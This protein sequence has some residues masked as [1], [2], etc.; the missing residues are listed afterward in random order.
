MA[1]AK[2]S[3]M[4]SIPS[5]TSF[6][7]LVREVTKKMAESAGFSDGTADRLALAV[8][9]ATTNVIEHAYHGASGKVVEVRM[10][11]RGIATRQGRRFRLPS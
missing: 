6:L 3:L 4:L 2:P 10:E 1:R 9:E 11:D 7:S 8:D 5:Q